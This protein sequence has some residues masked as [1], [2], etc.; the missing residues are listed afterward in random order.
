MEEVRLLRSD[1]YVIMSREYQRVAANV[2]YL[3]TRVQG[4]VPRDQCPI[5]CDWGQ[6]TRVQWVI[7]V[8]CLDQ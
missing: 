5:S 7:G 4:L 3:V 6:V 2:Q 8:Q 1:P